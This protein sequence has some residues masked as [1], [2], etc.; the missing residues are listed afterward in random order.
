MPWT[1]VDF[2]VRRQ[3][4]KP[5]ALGPPELAG[6]GGGVGEV[7]VAFDPVPIDYLWRVE[8]LSFTCQNPSGSIPRAVLY[9]LPVNPPGTG[10]PLQPQTPG[11]PTSELFSLAPVPNYLPYP[12]SIVP[13]DFMREGDFEAGDFAAPITI[14]GGAQLVL[15]IELVEPGVIAYARGSSTPSTKGP[16]RNPNPSPG[17]RRRPWA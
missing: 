1:L 2:P 6:F 12:P 4:S 11:V 17:P 5:C 10:T 9:D 3:Q 14:Q 8:R 7:Q 16:R 15:A 13:V